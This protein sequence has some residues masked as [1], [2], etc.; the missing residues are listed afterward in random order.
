MKTRYR[1]CF[2]SENQAASLPL[3]FS[4]FISQTFVANF[5]ALSFFCIEQPLHLW[6]IGVY[7]CVPYRDA[8]GCGSLALSFSAVHS[9]SLPYH[10]WNTKCTQNS[11][12]KNKWFGIWRE[13]KELKKR[14]GNAWNTR[15]TRNL[16]INMK[17]WNKKEKCVVKPPIEIN[18]GR[19]LQPAR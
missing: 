17:N 16:N 12:W 11:R 10:V 8:S 9:S 18:S 13:M 5:C 2:F 19:A 4:S 15:N 3:Y 14:V 7:F 1:L 6:K